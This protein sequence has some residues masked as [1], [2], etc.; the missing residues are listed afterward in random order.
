MR[1]LLLAALIPFS[2][3]GCLSVHESPPPPKNTT[4]VVPPGST[5]TCSNGQPGPC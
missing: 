4:I 1:K 3:A 5:V 2:L